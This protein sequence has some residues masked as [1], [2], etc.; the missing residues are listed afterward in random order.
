MGVRM[1]GWPSWARM[2]P[3]R[4]STM[5]CTTLWG[6]ITTWMRSIGMENSQCASMTSSPL[7]SMVAESTEILRPMRRLGREAAAPAF[8]HGLPA[9][10]GMDHDLD[11]FH[12]H[13]NQP[14]CLDDFQPFVQ[15]GG[16]IHG[17]LAAPAPVGVCAGRIGGACVQ[18]GQGGAAKRP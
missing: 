16:R 12:R 6:W 1:S 7:F 11:A 5:E 15:H 18:L 14:V 8:G 10:R 17:N 3:S 13:G 4:Y 9:A 2:E